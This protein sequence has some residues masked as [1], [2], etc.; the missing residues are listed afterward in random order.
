MPT[1]ITIDPSFQQVLAGITEASEI[2]DENGKIIGIFKPKC[3][4]DAEVRAMTAR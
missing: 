1:K 3:Q 4:M 2:V